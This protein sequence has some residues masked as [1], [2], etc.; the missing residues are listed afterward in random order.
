MLWMEHGCM[1]ELKNTEQLNATFNSRYRREN[2][3]MT[4][5]VS[6]KTLWVAIVK[7]WKV[8]TSLCYLL[9]ITSSYTTNDLAPKRYQPGQSWWWTGI[10]AKPKIITIAWRHRTLFIDNH[11]VKN[12]VDMLNQISNVVY[13]VGSIIAYIG[14]LCKKTFVGKTFSIFWSPLIPRA[15]SEGFQIDKTKQPGDKTTQQLK[16]NASFVWYR[17]LI[18]FVFNHLCSGMRPVTENMSP[19]SWPMNH[20]DVI[21]W[22]HFPRYWPFVHPNKQLSKQSG[23]WWFETPSCP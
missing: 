1:E 15:I 23:G 3:H 20:D 8:L 10:V 17:L 22:K 14:I 5:A 16:V 6:S 2:D 4:S 7:S 12:V 13:T 21:K 19:G 9:N 18:H 11:V